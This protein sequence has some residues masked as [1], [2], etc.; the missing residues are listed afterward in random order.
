MPWIQAT[1][2]GQKVLVKAKPDGTFDA[3]GG[4]V[5]IRYKPTDARAYRAGVGNLER[6]VGAELIADWKNVCRKFRKVMPVEYRR[7]LAELKAQ[8]DK[9]PLLAAAGA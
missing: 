7:A 5:E 9:Q 2:R 6:I 8:E 4:R 3:Q 1:L